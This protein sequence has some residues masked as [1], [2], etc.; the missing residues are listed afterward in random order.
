[1]LAEKPYSVTSF[2]DF[3]IILG[4]ILM[5]IRTLRPKE[6]KL[7]LEQQHDYVNR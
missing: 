3:S 5:V 6:G 7:E 2:L 1:M 4:V